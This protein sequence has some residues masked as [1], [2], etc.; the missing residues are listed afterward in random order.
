MK[1]KLLYIFAALS[2][3]A[4]SHDDI[5]EPVSFDI[6]LDHSNTYS[7]GE[8]VKFLVEGN[9]DNLLFYSGETGSQYKYKD[10]Y[11]VSAESVKSAKLQLDIKSQYG[12]PD[13]LDIYV[14][15]AFDG[16]SGVD[17]AA[18]REKIKKLVKDNM[19]GW[20][21]MDF[22]EQTNKWTSNFID[23]SDCLDNFC[24]AIHWHPKRDGK[25]AQRTYLVNGGINL[26]IEGAA[27]TK[28]KISDLGLISVMMN[29]EI[30]D[31]YK[32]NAGQGS[33]IFNA[34]AT[35]EIQF[36]GVA[37]T[38]LPYALDAWVFC[39]PSQLNKVPNDKGIV[40][41]N[42][43]NYMK[44]FQYNYMQPGNYTATIVGTNRNYKGVSSSVKQLS[45][46]IVDKL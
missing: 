30:N 28:L 31:P 9:V 37:A 11:N 13:G 4:C 40:V 22:D 26:E 5:S 2:L 6:K 23:V 16:L 42:M 33:I 38:Y 27:D 43:Q 12:N 45:V 35:A 25:S 17:G 1:H 41:K 18:D 20:K 24:M 39:V 32:K 10:R 14:S 8:P 3:A 21:K 19:P 29:E 44:S 36:K 34:P 46:H 7:A 15:N